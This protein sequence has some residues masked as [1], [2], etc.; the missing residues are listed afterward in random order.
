VIINPVDSSKIYSIYNV[1]D[2]VYEFSFDTPVDSFT[3][4]FEQTDSVF[5]PF[6]LSGILAEN[7]S[8]GITYN[9][10]GINGAS[11]MSWLKCEK[12]QKELPLVLPDLVIFG[13][14][15][16]D[17]V[18]KNFSGAKFLDN[19][20]KL[21]EKIQETN[22][23]AGDGADTQDIVNHYDIGRI[24]DAISRLPDSCR[25]MFRMHIA[26]Y[27]YNEIAELHRVPLST[28]K[29]HIHASRLIL[30]KEL[31]EFRL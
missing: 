8:N 16:N 24:Y 18:P 30:Q 17:A 10:V 13:I 12:F 27:R 15:I 29:N 25:S 20:S 19:Y 23:T 1:L 26:G 7:N 6:T 5:H 9:S 4:A 11:V 14:G 2:D 3:I 21:I 22:F 31:K 28:V